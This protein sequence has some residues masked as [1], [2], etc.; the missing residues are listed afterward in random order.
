MGRGAVAESGIDPLYDDL[1]KHGVTI[2]TAPF[3]GPFGRAFAFANPDEYVLT[4]P[5]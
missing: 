5:G 1:A 4:V 3:D 2:V